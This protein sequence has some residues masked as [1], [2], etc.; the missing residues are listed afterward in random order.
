VGKVKE[1]KRVLAW[2]NFS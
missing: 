2:T 1:V